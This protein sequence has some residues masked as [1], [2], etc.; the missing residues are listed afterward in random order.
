MRTFFEVRLKVYQHEFGSFLWTA[1][2]FLAI[3]LV[4]AIF[5]NYVDTTFLKRYD[6]G[7]MPLML[8]INGVLTVLALGLMN[9]FGARFLDH[10]LLSW[11]LI[12]CGVLVGGIFLMVRAGLVIAYPILFQVLHLQDTI[13]L[14]YLWNIAGDL[15][16]ARQGKR[17]FPLITAG[18]LL[19][20]TL[21]N[22]LT[23]PLAGAFGKDFALPL[24]SASC[25]GIALVLSCATDRVRGHLETTRSTQGPQT[26]RLSEIPSIIRQYPVIRYLLL[27]GLIPNILLPIFTYQFSVIADR[28]FA[29]EQTLMSFLS[30]FRGGMT[31]TVFC[32]LF[33]MGRLYSKIGL[34]NAALVQPV[35]YALVFGV[36]TG[37]FNVYVAACGQFTI[38]LIQQAVSGPVSKVLF[39]VVP[40]EIAAWSR[41][42]VRGTVVKVGL[43]L[44]SLLMLVLKPLVAPR[45]L[46][47]IAAC[48]A[49]YWVFEVLAFRRGYRAGLK[50]VILTEGLD[51]DKIQPSLVDAA[52]V[53]TEDDATQPGWEAQPDRV[54]GFPPVTSESALRMLDDSDERTRAQ[55]AATFAKIRDPRAV[56]RLVRLLD[57]REEVRKAAAE[58]LSGYGE[59]I[60]PVLETVLIGSPARVQR[61]ILEVIRLS[62]WRNMDVMPFVG[63]QLM[64]AYNNLIAIGSLSRI[65]DSPSVT[66]LKVHL[67]EE[68]R[69]ILSLIFHALW[70]NYADMRLM[71]EALCSVEASVAVEMIETT[72]DRDMAK[73]IVPLIDNIPIHERIR[74]GRRLLPLMQTE[75]TEKVLTQLTAR[76]GPT[77]RMLALH[78]IGAYAPNPVYLGVLEV[79]RDDPRDDIRQVATYAMNRCLNEGTE[80]PEAIELV[81]ELKNFILFDGMGI[82]ELHAI[83]SI[84]LRESFA[85]GEVIVREG[86]ADASVYLVT[87]GRINVYGD[88]GTSEEQLQGT[89]GAGAFWG[90]LRLFTELPSSYTY[91]AAEPVEILII[92]K[93]HFHEIMRI[94]PQIGMNLC[95]F[96]AIRLTTQEMN[97]HPQGT[98]SRRSL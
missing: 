19:G 68:N 18:Q 40:R 47:P 51:F 24:F 32:A 85:V 6:V 62:G 8:V 14:V 78:V 4:F 94:Y 15:F 13:L 82:K 80:M 9:R 27:V 89:M 5:R 57:D 67:E 26:R 35:N 1:S 58:A 54:L 43:I 63:Q 84:V 55:A 34:A 95:L 73:Y 64:M 29:S 72:L 59:S 44:G 11:F 91:A 92:R 7:Q 31:M 2:I 10:S 88:Y 21:G 37:F 22:F 12:A 65:D 36:L 38:R 25:L 53:A 41:V 52:Y 49:V 90:E 16:D 20:T 76:E 71:Y 17:I 96:F 46:A 77:T 79:F 48:M 30:F 39:N 42:F 23:Q 66:T 87:G 45:Y 98:A 74:L 61:G 56:V 69:E 70:V 83:A 93:H 50:Q 86:E 28:T 97:H 81:R 60:L 75:S 33:I 3:F